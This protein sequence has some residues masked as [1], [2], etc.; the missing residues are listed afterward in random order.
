MIWIKLNRN[1]QPV[2]VTQKEDTM[3]Q[4]VIKKRDIVEFKD[5]EDLEQGSGKILY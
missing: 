4:W 3:K 5:E 2:A 1:F